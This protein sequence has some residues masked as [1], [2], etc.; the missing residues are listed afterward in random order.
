MTNPTEAQAPAA[1]DFEKLRE[2]A[3]RHAGIAPRHVTIGTINL[4]EEIWNAALA[5]SSA[6]RIALEKQLRETEKVRDD[7]C[8]EFTKARDLLATAH[9]R[10][11]E[12]MR[13]TWQSIE[14]I[15]DEIKKN[16]THI[17]VAL[18]PYDKYWTFDQRPPIVVHYFPDPDEPGFYP[19]FGIVQ[20]SYNDK[21]VTFTHWMPIP[22]PPAG[23]KE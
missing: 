20:D 3:A 21:P 18:G 9:Q 6:E 23:E 1:P 4:C 10:A 5:S 11:A 22:I 14:T 12:A 13:E 8:A 19:S 16:G 15:P 7:W 2:I 17:L